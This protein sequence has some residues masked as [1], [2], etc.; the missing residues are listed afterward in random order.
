MKKN[1]NPQI[2]QRSNHTSHTLMPAE[3]SPGMHFLNDQKQRSWCLL[4]VVHTRTD[5]HSWLNLQML[6]KTF[7]SLNKFSL[8]TLQ[9][10]RRKVPRAVSALGQEAVTWTQ[11]G[12]EGRTEPELIKYNYDD[13]RWR[14]GRGWDLGHH[15][16]SAGLNVWSQRQKLKW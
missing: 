13:Q 1:Q 14:A 12:D 16:K 5:A 9:M 6:E 4:Q 7:L 10:W 2:L 15:E 3:R 8:E 11:Q